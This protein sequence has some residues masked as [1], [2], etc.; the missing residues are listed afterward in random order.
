VVVETKFAMFVTGPS[1]RLP[2][3]VDHNERFG[4]RRY[5]YLAF[6]SPELATA[7]AIMIIE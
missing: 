4:K 6:R 5:P 7:Q 1:L 3:E 2:F